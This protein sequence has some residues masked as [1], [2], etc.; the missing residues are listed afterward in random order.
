[1]NSMR[2]LESNMKKVLCQLF[3]LFSL[4]SLTAIARANLDG[5]VFD[6]AQG[7]F[8]FNTDYV[9]KDFAVR[10]SSNSSVLNLGNIVEIG[11]YSIK[12]GNAGSPV[13]MPFNNSAADSSS[14]DFATFKEGDQIGIYVKMNGHLQQHGNNYEWISDDRIYTYTSTK[15]AIENADGTVKYN[16]V[17]DIEDPQ[18]FSLFIDN[19]A[20]HQPHYQYA[21]DGEIIDGGG[22]GGG[23]N[24]GGQPLPGLLVTLAIG[25]TALAGVARKRKNKKA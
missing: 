5:D 24:L 20:Q 2:L 23:D 21:F 1:M 4:L 16:A 25:G 13:A 7:V 19:H 12:D 17:D 9:L 10:V 8:T 18:F 11:Y 22:E 14:S 15:G 6:Y 3:L